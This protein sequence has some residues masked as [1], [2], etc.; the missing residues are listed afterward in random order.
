MENNRR[1]CPEWGRK[2]SRASFSYTDFILAVAHTN[3]LSQFWNCMLSPLGVT[4]N[5]GLTMC[6]H[7][8]PKFIHF[9]LKQYMILFILNKSELVYFVNIYDWFYHSTSLALLY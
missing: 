2:D 6:G 5:K 4:E 7:E 9:F 1:V 8:E 3:S